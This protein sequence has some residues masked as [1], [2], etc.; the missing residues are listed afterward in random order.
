M[1]N[2]ICFDSSKVSTGR[3]VTNILVRTYSKLLISMFYT[4][5]K[6]CRMKTSIPQRSPSPCPISGMVAERKK[7][8]EP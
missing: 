6:R 5:M 1:K 2:L 8:F 7:I 3:Y 4:D